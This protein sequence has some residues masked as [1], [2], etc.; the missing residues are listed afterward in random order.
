MGKT[1][2]EK[3]LIKDL[4]WDKVLTKNWSKSGSCYKVRKCL[5]NSGSENFYFLYWDKLVLLV[6]P[7]T[8]L[9][10][11]HHVGPFQGRFGTSVVAVLKHSLIL[12]KLNK[13]GLPISRNFW[14]DKAHFLP[15]D[16]KWS[17]GY[18][19]SC[20]RLP[21]NEQPKQS[22]HKQFIWYENTSLQRRGS[23]AAAESPLGYQRLA[24]EVTEAFRN[25]FWEKN[26]QEPSHS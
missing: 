18:S 16:C 10:D 5:N 23:I 13:E 20:Q 15:P 3:S 11:F 2:R 21:A 14:S 1:V 12:S 7:Q 4:R 24:S 9:V 17:S 8:P 26:L 6:S 22:D 19:Q 25:N